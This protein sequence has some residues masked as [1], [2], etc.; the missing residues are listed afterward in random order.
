L[1]ILKK[2][3]LLVVNV[4]TNVNLVLGK[5]INVIVA[6]MIIEILITNVNVLILFIIME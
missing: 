6:Q 3:F 2:V 1:D 4:I 5:V